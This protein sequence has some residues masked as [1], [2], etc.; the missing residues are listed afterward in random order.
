[1]SQEVEDIREIRFINPRPWVAER[2]KQRKPILV[3][4]TFY[5]WCLSWVEDVGTVLRSRDMM[6]F[7]IASA[8]QYVGIMVIISFLES[9][10]GESSLLARLFKLGFLRRGK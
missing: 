9:L 10:L 3:S 7:T 5:Q 2:L 8:I 4:E 6:V 1:M